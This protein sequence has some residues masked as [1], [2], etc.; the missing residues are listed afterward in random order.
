MNVDN[1][2]G[3]ALHQRAEAILAAQG[4]R[5]YHAD[6]YLDAVAAAETESAE[7]EPDPE[8]V[9]AE[10]SRLENGLGE[11]AWNNLTQIGSEITA[12][13]YLAEIERL[14]ATLERGPR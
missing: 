13:R 10:R 14:I 7:A 12:E 2:T 11:F 9:R 1:L 3:G 6:D 4:K 5:G 8:A